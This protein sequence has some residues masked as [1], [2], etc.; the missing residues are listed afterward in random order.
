MKKLVLIV[1]ILTL[2][3]NSCNSSIEDVSDIYSQ[4]NSQISE[5]E[6]VSKLEKFSE[7]V[8]KEIENYPMLPIM[9]ENPDDLLFFLYDD[10]LLCDIDFD[11]STLF[12]GSETNHVLTIN[13]FSDGAICGITGIGY[14]LSGFIYTFDDGVLFKQDDGINSFLSDGP[15]VMESGYMAYLPPF[16]EIKFY[17]IDGTPTDFFLDFDYGAPITKDRD[18]L[19]YTDWILD[20]DNLHPYEKYTFSIVYDPYSEQYTILYTT[21]HYLESKD[22]MDEKF[23]GLLHRPCYAAIFDK[24]GNQ[25]DDFRIENMFFEVTSKMYTVAPMRFVALPDSK[26]FSRGYKFDEFGYIDLNDHIYLD[27]SSS[28]GGLTESDI[29]TILSNNPNLVWKS[30]QEAF[31]S[32]GYYKKI[33]NCP[34]VIDASDGEVQV[35]DADGGLLTI[36]PDGYKLAFYSFNTDGSCNLVFGS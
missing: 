14:D 22:E 12:G 13:H 32:S 1:L 20:S 8:S 11:A 7:T 19:V 18:D 4:V 35:L 2:I 25:T 29:D 5:I 30:N 16:D 24:Y 34:V 3:F 36:L 28:V 27:D 10:N 6:D 15:F 9:T 17:N 33:A 21:S 31:L 23:D 26:L